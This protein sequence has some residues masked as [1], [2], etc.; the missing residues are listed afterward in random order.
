MTTKQTSLTA[1]LADNYLPALEDALAGH[2][3]EVLEYAA[4]ARQLAPGDFDAALA[5]IRHLASEIRWMTL[6][7]QPVP[8]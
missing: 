7:D 4:G 6:G 3:H 2:L 5:A 8:F 1:E